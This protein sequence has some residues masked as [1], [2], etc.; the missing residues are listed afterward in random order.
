[1]ISVFIPI[2]KIN[3]MQQWAKSV[4]IQCFEKK[5]ISGGL[6][7]FTF[8][9]D[10]REIENSNLVRKLWDAKK[11]NKTFVETIL[12]FPD[13]PMDLLKKLCGEDYE[14]GDFIAYFEFTLSDIFYRY[15][16]NESGII[17]HI[18]SDDEMY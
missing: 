13:F 15:L 10:S 4:I 7:V 3:D 1:M 14:T 18:S 5:I 12:K 17:L 16:K 9:D 2:N 8:F 6:E 11:Q